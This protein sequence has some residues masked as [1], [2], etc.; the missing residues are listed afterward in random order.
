MINK[1]YDH[2]ITKIMNGKVLILSDTDLKG[3]NIKLGKYYYDET[4]FISEHE[5]EVGMFFKLGKTMRIS[6]KTRLKEHLNHLIGQQ[7][8][9]EWE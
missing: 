7:Y 5:E 8:T 6:G 9:L 1:I 2:D 4:F 3:N